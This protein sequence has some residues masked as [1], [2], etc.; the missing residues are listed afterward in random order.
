MAFQDIRKSQKFLSPADVGFIIGVLILIGALLALNIY[1]SRTLKGGE[2][3]YL[4]WSGARAFSYE[5]IEPYGSTI[6][7]RVQMFVYGREAYLNDYPYA[8]NDP[9]YIVLLYRPLASFSD[10][11][12][13]RGIWMLFAQ[14]A[15]IGIVLLSLNLT[16]WRPPTWITVTLVGFG[17]FSSFSVNSLLSGSPAIFLTFIYLC[18]LIALRSYS[19][20]LAGA[21]LFLVAYQWE[22]SA[23]FFIFILVFV[24]ANRRWS[25]FVGFVMTLI[26]LLIISLISNS[27]W[28]V[29]YLR[30]ALFD[31][32]LALDITFGIT[33]SYIFPGINAF[34]GRWIA[35]AVAG[36]LLFESIRAVNSHFRHIVWAACLSLA[37]NPLMG[38]AIFPSDQSVLLPAMVLVILLV[39]ERWTKRRVI[40]SILLIGF[41]FLLS[42]GLYLQSIYA[43]TRLYSDLLKILPPVLA[44]AGLYWMRWW[45][46]RAPRVWADQIGVHK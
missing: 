37:L 12:V 29:S 45:A 10:F 3:L 30:A 2:W 42:Y 40:V 26:A 11:A 25:V 46:V 17:L 33:L 31:W 35:V 36:I 14:A 38:F 41:V 20:E 19:D 4:R 32:R 18:I 9:F 1:L 22:V 13:A 16:E 43:Q 5:R 7:E 15:L 6:A 39:W 21:L 44:A 23:L 28:I 34:M 24:F 27:N 8:L